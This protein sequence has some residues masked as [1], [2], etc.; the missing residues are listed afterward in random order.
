[1]SE[2]DTKCDSIT[3]VEKKSH[4]SFSINPTCGL[5]QVFGRFLNGL[6]VLR[7]KVLLLQLE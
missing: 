2:P 1:M 7:I 3:Q 5:T 4:F 6:Y